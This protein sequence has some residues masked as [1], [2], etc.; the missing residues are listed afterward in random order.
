MASRIVVGISG[1]SG[2]VYARRIIQLLLDKNIQVHLVVSPMGQR[3]LHDELGIEA[4]NLESLTG[5]SPLPRIM[6]E[7]TDMAGASGG[8][9]EAGEPAIVMHSYRDLGAA[10]ASGSF[11]HQGMVIVPCS[12]NSLA[13]VATG[14]QQ[15]LMHRA[16]HVTLKERRRLVLV[17]RELPLSL[18][19]IENMQKATQAGAIICP[20]SPGFY[21]LPKTIDD[22]VDFVAC[23]V[24][25][26]LQIHHNLPTRWPPNS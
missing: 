14:N 26:L 4:L 1:A 17:H 10:I 6:A 12:S 23:R 20:A 15:N 5:R 21:M 7:A 16:A 3:L 11:L 8:L 18:I 19:D 13:A 22:L 24:L 2:A 25:D 9:V